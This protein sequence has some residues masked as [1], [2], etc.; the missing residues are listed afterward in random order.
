[1]TP[2]QPPPV[3]SDRDYHRK[4]FVVRWRRAEYLAIRYLS[5]VRRVKLDG[6]A[7]AALA[8][9]IKE[10]ARQTM[11]EDVARGREVNQRLAL[12]ARG[13]IFTKDDRGESNLR[14]GS[15]S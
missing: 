11:A 8:I 5:G 12:L 3:K 4:P 1:M 13:E 2:Q 10:L 14:F 6:L 7:Q 9:G 15:G